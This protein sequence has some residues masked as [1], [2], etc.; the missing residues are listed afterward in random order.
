[1]ELR[2]YPIWCCIECATDQLEKEGRTF[3]RLICTFH[4]GICGVCFEERVITEPRDFGYPQWEG[5]EKP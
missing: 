1:M 2:P 4:Q 3:S 5:F